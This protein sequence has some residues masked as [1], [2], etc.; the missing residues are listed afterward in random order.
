MAQL[1][2]SLVTLGL[3]AGLLAG[4][5]GSSGSSSSSGGSTS[6]N[7]LNLVR[8]SIGTGD[9]L[10][11][12]TFRLSH[13]NPTNEVIDIRTLDDLYANVTAAN[14]IQVPVRFADT[15]ILPGGQPGNHYFVATFD[16]SL[17]IDSI[18]SNLPADGG[19]RG[20]I[21]V[22]S[23]NPADGSATE[24]QGRAFI[25][26]QTYAGQP[27]GSPQS[28]P[29]QDWV[30]RDGNS[31]VANPLID[32]NLD[33][34]PDGLGFPGTEGEYAGARDLFGENVFVFVADADSNLTTHE[35]FPA[36]RELR[37]FITTEVYAT[38]GQQLANQAKAG[39]TVGPDT[40]TPE[41]S[42]T[43]APQ[44]LL[45]AFPRTVDQGGLADP[46]TEIEVQFTEAVQPW[47]FGDLPTMSVPRL[48]PAFSVEFGPASARTSV[49]CAVRPISPFDL[50]T[51]ILT[52]AFTF[53]G[54]GP[55]FNECGVFN[56]VDVTIFGSQFR[57]L[58]ASLNTRAGTR[59][60]F[61][62]EGP[63][64][65][66]VPITPEAIYI[67]RGGSAPGMSIIDMNGFGASTG[68][69]TFD[70][71]SPVVEGNTNLP[72]NPNVRFQ[73]GV[74]IPPVAAGTCTING[75]S[76]GVFT[77][78][79]D[80]SLDDK[81]ARN[82]ILTNAGDMMLG[83]A[84]D[85]T[86]N[87]GPAPFGCQGGGGNLCANTGLKQV[88]IVIDGSAINPATGNVANGN[89]VLV[90]GGPN[91][92][93]WS[94][95]PNP[96][97]LAFPPLCV[98]P[99]I[100]GQEPTSIATPATNLL[101]GGDPFGNPAA[102]IPPSGLIATQG[103]TFF[104][105]PARQDAVPCPTFGLRQQVGHFLYV[106]DRSRREIVVLN[107]NRM[108]VIDRLLLP[109]PTT[110][111]IGPNL[112]VLAVTNQGANQVSLIDIDPNSAT[113]HKIIKTIQVG[114]GP[115]G[116]AWDPGNEDI[117]V[118]NEG[119][120]S[121]SIISA[122]SFEVRKVVTANLTQPFDVAITPRQVNFGFNRV[123]YFAYIL[124]RTGDLA[125]FESG[126]N[127][128][129]G[130]GFDDIIGVTNQRFRNPKGIQPD[131]LELRSGVW[132]LHE[133]PLDPVTNQLAG[134][135]EEGAATN[136]VVSSSTT[137][138]IPL[139]VSAFSI[140]NFRDMNFSIKVSMGEER[141][142]GVPIDMAFDNMLNL[143]AVINFSTV[144][145]AGSPIPLNGKS[146]VRATPQTNGAA[147][148][149]VPRFAFFAVPNPNQGTGVVDVISLDGP[150]LRTDTNAFHDGIQSIPAENCQV[151]M[152]YFRQ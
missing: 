101:V 57:D 69:P 24:V 38:S 52:P 72:N 64:L 80:S 151:L 1:R 42:F 62:G 89:Q 119:A 5:G 46:E 11:Y 129:N 124:N 147:P 143:G 152:D 44:A 60:F 84:L 70:P 138:A 71:F 45:Q 50:S 92:V 8:V 86:F 34:T 125:I 36:G 93:S 128:V 99:F 58:S 21:K 122:F 104:Q 66:N 2:I 7:S 90:D 127:T 123:V 56:R 112:D 54:E 108:T 48:S 27:E 13:G 111:A 94:P 67:G 144:F 9:L 139:S 4:C 33:G 47:T 107:S 16:R 120:G 116:I 137:G 131:V 22:V 83:W 30:A 73:G 79:K 31:T 53:P 126:P 40:L 10:P 68:N 63:G 18:L 114:E 150:F 145:S 51:F 109:D 103:V 59:T 96:P 91:L 43:P 32:N 14:P 130:W 28:V 61:V 3:S 76:A 136:I 115:R 88:A 102:G 135:E 26:G 97:Q 78:T 23:I 134:G 148:V 100:G 117:I 37:L 132:V 74:L 65:V 110:L 141:L 81:V 106:V 29:L 113:F 20:T 149:S 17:N 49:P 140:P 25:N 118:C 75:G 87:N 15:A 12:K 121:I 95:H 19:L 55:E 85:T 133:G 142:S 41:A 6:G 105:G 77:L 82:P 39:T 35:T 146:L 98:S